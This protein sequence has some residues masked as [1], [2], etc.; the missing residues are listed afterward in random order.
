VERINLL[1]GAKHLLRLYDIFPKKRLGQHFIVDNDLLQKLVSYASITTD[2]IVLEVGPGLGFLTQLLSRRCKKVI[3]VEVDPT[4]VRILRKQLHNLQNVDLIKGDI[5]KTSLPPFTKVVSAPP[6]SI[7]SPLLFRLL[8]S[9]FDWAVLILQKEFAE[10]LAASVGTKNYGRLT[11]TIYYRADVE[12]LDFVPRKMFYPPPE[13]DSTILRLTPREPPFQVEDE[14]T[15]FE[16]VQ[17]L[18]TQRNKKIRNALIPFLRKWEM[19]RNE[20]VELADFTIY[21]AKRVR[22]LAPEDFAI[23]TSEL[24]RKL[25]S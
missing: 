8:G 2:D 17:I 7:S 23:L 25:T 3:A 24:L 21:R 22:E 10:R 5:L 16:L 15:F 13:V 6:Y 4:L 1:R 11:V 9:R 14:K 18:F 20:A 12:L 19:S